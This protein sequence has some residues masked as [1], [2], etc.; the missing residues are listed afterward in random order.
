[1]DLLHATAEL[2]S[3]VDRLRP[4]VLDGPPPYPS[5][6][7]RVAAE[8]VQDPAA[9]VVTAGRLRAEVAAAGL[10]D[11][12]RRYLDALLV[13][14]R[15]RA[16]LLAGEDVGYVEQVRDLFGVLPRRSEPDELHEAHRR[17]AAVLPGRGPL[18]ARM[19][20]H[21]AADVVPVERLAGAVTAVVAELRR[22][23]RDTLGLPDGEHADVDLVG[24]RPWTAFT[25]Y[26]GGLRSR[27]SV[28]TTGRVRAGSL[29]PLLAHEAYPGHHLQYCRA[30]V[31]SARYPELALRLVHSPQG[32]VAEGAAEAAV[33]VVPGPGWGAVAERVLAGAGVHLDGPAAERI[34]RELDLL[35]R[36]RLDAALMRHVDGAG[37]DAVLAH[38]SRWLLVDD[39]RARRML[40]FLDHPQWRTYPVTYAEGGPLVRAR[41]ATDPEGPA[42][43]LATLLDTPVLPSDLVTDGGAAHGPERGGPPPA[44]VGVVRPPR[45]G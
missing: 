7:R 26:R 30:E 9:L 8:P 39:D 6:A 29:L 11:G 44:A 34:E 20:D 21:R 14:L 28:A 2:A 35:G 27:I 45:L 19:R 43:A 23:T 41:L 32:L 25:R 33:A 4:G 40:D 15:C 16:R 1:M 13:A 18:A 12:R 10:P 3:R 22:R 24:A 42:A 5:I 38:L 17:L 31:A 37:P 36:V